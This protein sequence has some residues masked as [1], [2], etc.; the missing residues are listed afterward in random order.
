MTRAWQTALVTGSSGFIGQHLVQHLLTESI[1]VTVLR[2][3]GTVTRAGLPTIDIDAVTPSCIEGA[4]GSRRFDVVFHLAAYGVT[5][6]DRDAHLIQTVNVEATAALTRVAVTWPARAMVIAGSG[7]E[8]EFAGVDQPVTETHRLQT[9]NAY[10][11]SKTAGALAALAA[12]HGSQMSVAVARIF[13]V[14]GPGEAPH[15]LLPSLVHGLRPN[16]AIDLSEG[17]Q[18]RDFL[19]VSDVVRALVHIADAVAMQPQACVLNVASGQAVTVRQFC[20]TAADVMGIARSQ[21]RFGALPMRPDDTM[22]FAGDPGQLTTLTG[23]SPRL[24]L[25]EGLSA[26]VATLK[27]T[28]HETTLSE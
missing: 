27:Q 15:R 24:S 2:R 3:H 22:Y 8:Y 23:W 13:N 16:S 14:Y 4:L 1:A 26:T 6:T 28:G 17:T 18:R 10:G 21:L 7:S 9:R 12:A 19:H 25:V 20:E 5:P 11:A